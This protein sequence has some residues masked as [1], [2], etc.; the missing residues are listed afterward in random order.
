[1]KKSLLLS[2]ALCA[3]ISSSATVTD[4][5]PSGY[6]FNNVTEFSYYEKGCGGS[7]IA[8]PAWDTVDGTN[9][10][11]NGLVSVCGNP[12]YFAANDGGK[13]NFSKDDNKGGFTALINGTS[14]VNLGGEVGQVLCL[15]GVNS[16][17]NDKLTELYGIDLNIPKM[18]QVTGWFNINFFSDPNTTPKNDPKHYNVRCRVTL[19]V[20]HN[21]ITEGVL[22]TNPFLVANMGGHSNVPATDNIYTA[23]FI[24]Y[25]DDDPTG[26]PE[27]D[28]DNLVWN[29]NTW[30]VYEKNIQIGADEDGQ[31]FSPVRLK[32]G[33]EN[34]IH[35]GAI[36]IKS[37]EFFSVSADDASVATSDD[38]VKTTITLKPNPAA[39][40]IANVAANTAAEYSI[41]G[42]A[43]TF[44]ENATVYAISG[45]QVANAVAGEPVAL[46]AGFYVANVGGK[47]VKFVIK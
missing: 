37:V 5:T 11:N 10:F 2:A 1:M 40:G 29:P 20:Y 22:M 30:V 8:T 41:N 33:I 45:A 35:D 7:N 38:A 47:G 46:K 43:V 24:K 23:D 31:S 44:G 25:V 19:N 21:A 12:N 26:D 28:G 14:L 36:L 17:L 27:E 3:A 6:L 42:N 4:I 32:F 34:K 18:N 39:S 9:S 16:T 15:N 13:A